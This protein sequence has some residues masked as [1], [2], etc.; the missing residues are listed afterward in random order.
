MKRLELVL[1]I[2]S[3]IFIQ[4]CN[5]E[6]PVIPE[7]EKDE[8]GLVL[9]FEEDLQKHQGIIRRYKFTDNK[10]LVSSK[11][12]EIPDFAKEYSTSEN[13]EK[14]RSLIEKILATSALPY[15]KYAYI[16]VGKAN[17][18]GASGF[19]GYLN[20]D[21]KEMYISIS[22]SELVFDLRNGKKNK[23]SIHTVIHEF[24]HTVAENV[25]QITPN[26]TGEC[27]GGI[28][29]ADTN[30]CAKKE[31]Y[32][33]KFY[34]EFWKP[35]IDQIEADPNKFIKDHPEEFVTSYAASNYGEDIAESFTFFVLYDKPNGKEVKDKK[36]SFFYNYPEL[37]EMRTRIRK[38]LLILR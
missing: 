8:Q 14:L 26:S 20:E 35:V 11:E 16:H 4:S 7:K 27:N 29:N 34:N 19:I 21:L 17:G 22:L 23:E 2:M 30:G 13:Q 10:K 24:G 32:I 6:D 5:K 37:I 12:F 1:F 18:E 28:S 9:S 15:V 31:A 3:L 38:S 33:N 36:V 25:S